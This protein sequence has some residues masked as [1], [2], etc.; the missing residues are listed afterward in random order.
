MSVAR[1]SGSSPITLAAF[2]RRLIAMSYQGRSHITSRGQLDRVLP[3]IPASAERTRQPALPWV[4]T[5]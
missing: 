2:C 5:S 3:A 1:P 4:T